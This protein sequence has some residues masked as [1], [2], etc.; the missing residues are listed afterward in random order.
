MPVLGRPVPQ[1]RDDQHALAVQH[2]GGQAGTVVKAGVAV[3]DG[4]A[5]VKEAAGCVAVHGRAH[6]FG[7]DRQQ[8]L[9]VVGGLA[10]QQVARRA[11]EAVHRDGRQIQLVVG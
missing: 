5:L 6:P 8:V 7:V 2:V 11:R 9:L 1:R 3:L 10:D 4:E